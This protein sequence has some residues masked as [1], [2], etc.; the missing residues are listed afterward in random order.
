MAK[1]SIL[2]ILIQLAKR[3]NADKE[4]IKGLADLKKTVT[5]AGVAFGVVSAAAL[6]LGMAFKKVYEIGKA[7]AEL[8]L[9]RSRFDRLAASIGTTSDALMGDL[10]DATRG[11]YSD[12]QLVESA[13]NLMGLGLAKS[14]EE[15]VR[16]SSVSSALNMDM[17]QLVLTLTNMTTMRF[18]ALGVSVDGFKERVEAL[19]AS[20]MD[21]DAAFKEAFLQQAEEQIKKV[22]HAADTSM[23][24][25]MQFEA[26]AENL[27]A[28][29]ERFTAAIVA[30]EL[31][32]L[33]KDL[34][35]ATW[36]VQNFSAIW[37]EM[38]RLREEG[39]GGKVMGFLDLENL[40]IQAEYNVKMEQGR[41]KQDEYLK[42]VFATKDGLAEL[43]ETTKQVKDSAD[44]YN[45]QIEQLGE[46]MGGDLG[47]AQ[48]DYNQ[49][50]AEYKT[51]LE[52]A[53]GEEE[54]R[55]IQSKIDAETEAYNK[56]AAAIMFNIQ[57]Q[58][59]MAAVEADP[60]KQQ[61]AVMVLGQL[62]ESYGLIDEAQKHAMVSSAS[63]V[64]MWMMGT[65]T[66][67]QFTTM[68]RAN[69]AGVQENA[70][71]L[72]TE[73]SVIGHAAERAKDTPA[74]FSA[75]AE[76]QSG[77]GNAIRSDALPAVGGLRQ[78][79]AGL[80]QDGSAWNWT[81]SITG[82]GSF[83]KIPGGGQRGNASGPGAGYEN[84]AGVDQE[85]AAGGQMQLG[86]GWSMVGEEG[87]ELV[88]PQGY[89]F[90]HEQSMAL[91]SGASF[92]GEYFKFGSGD[93]TPGSSTST[94]S[95]PPAAPKK[96][97]KK[98]S[99]E[100]MSPPSTSSSDLAM[101]TDASAVET[102]AE[103]TDV[104]VQS[105]AAAQKQQVAEGIQTRNV[106]A[107]GNAEMAGK[108]DEIRAELHSLNS[109]LPRSITAAMI[110]ANP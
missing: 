22:G 36:Q 62:A 35:A 27:K 58:A 37:A 108:L 12:A 73:A 11:L 77:L 31:P 44:L 51:Q 17:N 64:D 20:G 55:D 74:A 66:T 8:E 21:A 78:E 60:T 33:T 7:G 1:T 106:I 47:Q 34:D 70:S 96:K 10:K 76:A 43:D 91:M 49:K 52:Q 89:V 48:D 54:K 23:G 40:Q 88:S 71:A 85:F 102:L 26:S 79:L 56:R 107:Q 57:Q 87:Y 81:Y 84:N 39:A 46:Y 14:H 38:V 5:D 4:V 103:S 24:S 41:Q 68:L 83:P 6:G 98:D 32:Q 92:A 105:A 13:A 82:S 72:S 99:D 95:T 28:T 100:G 19:K 15:A 9:T 50:I 29:F 2:S 75:M 80:P 61:E 86:R 59:I 93:V 18:D 94:S 45:Q 109:T 90:T 30:P 69:T 104:A 16:L 67:D 65:L 42:S 97:K 25:F 53:R 101:S 110:Q 3:G 63:L